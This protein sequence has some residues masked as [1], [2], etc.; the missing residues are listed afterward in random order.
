MKSLFPSCLPIVAAFL[1]ISC[2]TACT[3]GSRSQQPKAVC[4]T[5]DGPLVS[6]SVPAPVQR[7]LDGA[8][9]L[10]QY[11]LMSDSAAQLSV[12]AVAEAD[13][14]STQ[15]YGIVVHKGAQSTTFAHLRNT[16]QPKAWF[17]AG[18]GSLWLATSAMEGTGVQVEQLSLIRF[19]PD[20]KAYIAAAID[21]FDI[22]QMLC[23]RL[24][25]VAI[26]ADHAER[27][28]LYIDGE[29]AD[30]LV[31]TVTDMGLYDDDALWVGEQL[32]YE[33]DGARPRLCVTPGV[34]YVTGLVLTYDDTPTLTAHISVD[35]D[36]APSI[37]DLT[38]L[39]PEAACDAQ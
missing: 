24:S 17:D 36:G 26:G 2:L 33:F 15:G 29:A 9:I 20:G 21:P 6:D 25:Y 30:T 12:C 27:I 1:S 5:L 22:Q 31:N 13:E 37:T 35:A 3:D 14:Q 39:A 19:Q 11:E 18:T 32:T 16:R 23:Q 34:K 4:G 28:E 8:T 38:V 10:H 7:V